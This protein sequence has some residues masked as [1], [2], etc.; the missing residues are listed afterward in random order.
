VGRAPERTV[1]A[2]A[3]DE[4][5]AKRVRDVLGYTQN[6]TERRMFGGIAFMVRGNMCCGVLD[7]KL[8][9]RV[10]PVA[11]DKVLRLT[12]SREMDFTG[13]AMR[14]IVYV[15][16]EGTKTA[17]QLRTWIQRGLEFVRTLPAK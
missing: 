10:G 15:V 3:Y 11:Y 12:H 8:M 9:V 17:R 1:A 13:K 2:V 16:P 5:L 6:V 14:G 7:D 4:K